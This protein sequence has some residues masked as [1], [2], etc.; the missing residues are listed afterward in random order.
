MNITD[1][2]ANGFQILVVLLVLPI[3]LYASSDQ[4]SRA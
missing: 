2:F 4:V 3:R 1:I